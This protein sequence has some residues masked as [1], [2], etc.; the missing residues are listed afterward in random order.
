M[1]SRRKLQGAGSVMVN[2]TAAVEFGA[3]KSAQG[4]IR[5]GF[6]YL[7]KHPIKYRNKTPFSA[8]CLRTLWGR[9]SRRHASS[10][11]KRRSPAPTE[12]PP[13]E[14]NGGRRRLRSLRWTRGLEARA[15]ESGTDAKGCRAWA[16]PSVRAA[17]PVARRQRR[18]DRRAWVRNPS[19]ELPAGWL[20]S[21]DAGAAFTSRMRSLAWRQCIS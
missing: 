9:E 14:R 6:S 12:V 8:T 13:S 18:L 2:R 21:F 19:A 15:S 3:S 11:W 5:G 17:E 20:T 16:D 4:A 10:S 7:T 1:R